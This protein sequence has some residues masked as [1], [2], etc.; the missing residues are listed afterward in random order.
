MELELKILLQPKGHVIGG[1]IDGTSADGGGAPCR[2][3]GAEWRDLQ[4][5][6][7]PK[8]TILQEKSQL[9]P[10]WCKQNKR[11]SL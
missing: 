2:S 6:N 10:Q 7:E 5:G 3:S 1:V 4:M 11:E 8:C 9:E